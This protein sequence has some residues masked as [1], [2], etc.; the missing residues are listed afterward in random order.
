MTEDKLMVTDEE[1]EFIKAIENY[2]IQED[3]L[4]LSWREVL[5]IV[6]SLGYENPFQLRVGNDV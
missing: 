6:K 4:F 1:K 3:K 5:G 2:K